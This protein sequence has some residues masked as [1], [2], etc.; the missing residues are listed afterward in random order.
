MERRDGVM[1]TVVQ[2][3]AVVR[4]CRQLVQC[5][6]SATVLTCSMNARSS[7]LERIYSCPEVAPM[8]QAASLFLQTSQ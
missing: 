3:S 1:H 5:D 7:R 2:P 6:V 8:H 4:P